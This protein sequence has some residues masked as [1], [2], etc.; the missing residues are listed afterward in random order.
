MFALSSVVR[1]AKLYA[2][3]PTVSDAEFLNAFLEAYVQEGR[4]KA[5]MGS[6]FVLDKYRTSKLLSGKIDVPKQLKKPLAQWGIEERTAKAFEPFLEEYFDLARFEEFCRSIEELL[7]DEQNV[8]LEEQLGALKDDPRSYFAHCFIAAIKA[9]N[10]D[11]SSKMIWCCGTGSF[12]IEVGDL[13]N[14]GFGR[15]KKRKNI[16][17]IPVNTGF[18]TKITWDYEGLAAPLVSAA[19]IHG[20]WLDRMF[21]CGESSETLRQRI[22][23]DLSKRSV[24]GK[25]EKVS[26]GTVLYEYDPGTIAMVENEKA[27]FYLLAISSFDS[28]NNAQSSPEIISNSLDRLFEHYDACGQGLDM[29]L[30]LLGTGMSRAH[31]AQNDSFSLIGKAIEKNQ[32][33]LHGKVTLVIRP[34]DKAKID[35]EF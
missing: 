12:S 18:D 24:V 2:L 10:L 28:K 30:P 19:S 1:T 34:S 29:F 3:D 20:Q 15:P 33:H 11:S 21:K 31:L 23:N 9:S 13:L 25:G 22:R 4:V 16:V 17:V 26:C 35:I 32:K 6:E 14:K 8:K 27:V 7:R 5:K